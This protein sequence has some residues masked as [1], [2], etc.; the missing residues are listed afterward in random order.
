MAAT[1]AENVP[2]ALLVRVADR[3]GEHELPASPGP[4]VQEELA[5]FLNRQGPYAQL[6]IRLGSGEY[7]RYDHVV[8]IRIHDPVEDG[9]ASARPEG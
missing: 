9:G 8:S 7:V 2:M 3:D 1:V 6:W 4:T 5:R